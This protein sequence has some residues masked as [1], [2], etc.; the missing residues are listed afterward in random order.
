MIFTAFIR[1]LLSRLS[2][3]SA[4]SPV[5]ASRRFTQH[6]PTLSTDF[7]SRAA[8][9]GKPRGL[10]WVRCDWLPEQKLVRERETGLLTLLAGIN[11]HFE[12]VEGGEMEDVAAVSSV[13]DA[14]A[15]F[16]YQNGSWGTGG[17]VLFNMHPAEAAERLS[18]SFEPVAEN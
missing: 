13:R 2:A 11:L 18:A 6:F 12:A 15:V 5:L 17:R 8:A 4:D 14:C 10:K 3:V 16:H 7:F 1:R 9:S